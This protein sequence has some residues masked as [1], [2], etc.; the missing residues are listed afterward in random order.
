[1]TGR[2][3]RKG[4]LGEREAAALLTAETGIEIRRQLGAGRTNS[5]GGDV[6][7][8]EG[9]PYTVIQVANKANTSEAC[10]NKPVEVEMQKCN[11]KAKFAASM[12]R[13]R[14]GKWRVVL[15]VAQFW[16]ILK[17]AIWA[18]ENGYKG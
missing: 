14:G 7:D 15:T 3:K 5:A 11:A 18:V 13:W 9:L 16:K 2:A 6:G 17:A 1:M 8:L 4:D 10:L 12:I